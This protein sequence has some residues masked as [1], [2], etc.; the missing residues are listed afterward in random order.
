MNLDPH[1]IC[2]AKSSGLPGT[3]MNK[4][5]GAFLQSCYVTEDSEE[6]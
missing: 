3:T 4:Y 6:L 2:R 5:S 1:Q